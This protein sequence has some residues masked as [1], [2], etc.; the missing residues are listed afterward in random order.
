MI[1]ITRKITKNQGQRPL[2]GSTASSIAA[3]TQ[4]RL[5]DPDGDGSLVY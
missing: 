3:L 5:G 4:S 1:K 2:S